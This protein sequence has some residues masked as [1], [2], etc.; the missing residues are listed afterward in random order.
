MVRHLRA[1]GARGPS[2]RR[3]ALARGRDEPGTGDEQTRRRRRLAAPGRGAGAVRSSLVPGRAMMANKSTTWMVTGVL[4]VAGVVAG[5]LASNS[6]EPTQDPGGAIVVTDSG[7]GGNNSGTP[8]KDENGTD[9]PT[10]TTHRATR[11]RAAGGMTAGP[12]PPTPPSTRARRRAPV[13]P[14]MWTPTMA[15]R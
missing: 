3:A 8:G 6:T 13:T 14:T 10:A 2:G 15:V 5:A 9:E 11:S 4:G 7:A 1:R 12:Q